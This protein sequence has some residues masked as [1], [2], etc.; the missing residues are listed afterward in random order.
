ML[1]SIAAFIAAA[2]LDQPILIGVGLVL[3]GF[4][5]YST[6]KNRPRR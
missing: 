5:V 3:F 1:M 4:V 2:V 6:I